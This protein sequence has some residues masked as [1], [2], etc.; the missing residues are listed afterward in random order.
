MA[1]K[2]TKNA[3]SAS[4][5]VMAM[6]HPITLLMLIVGLIGLGFLAF[7]EM[8]V[9]IF[10]RMNVP[11]IYVFFDF[12]GM[13]P[14]QIEG[15]MVNELELYFQYVDG[16]SDIKSRNIQIAHGDSCGPERG[17]GGGDRRGLDRP[18]DP[19]VPA[20]LAERARGR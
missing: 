15:F 16:I 20:R 2:S 6:D 7:E 9:N 12:I 8:Q 10:P 19:L 14:D 5:T 1:D 18:D 13:S 4:P 11:K 3:P 17:H